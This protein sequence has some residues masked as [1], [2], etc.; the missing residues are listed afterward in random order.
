M[1]QLGR[2]QKETRALLSDVKEADDEVQHCNSF[3]SRSHCYDRLEY[4][5]EYLRQS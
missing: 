1:L 3:A 2:L 4:A 5:L